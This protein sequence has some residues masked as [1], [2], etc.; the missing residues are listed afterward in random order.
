MKNALF[1]FCES[2]VTPFFITHQEISPFVPHLVWTNR[3]IMDK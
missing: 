2:K 1:L 3:D